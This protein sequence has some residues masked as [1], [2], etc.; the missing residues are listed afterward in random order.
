MSKV[1]A[2]RSQLRFLGGDRAGLAVGLDTQST[3]SQD[4]PSRSGDYRTCVLSLRH[5]Y[6]GCGMPRL[7]RSGD[8]ANQIPAARSLLFGHLPTGLRLRGMF[9]SGQWL[10][11]QVLG[12]PKLR[13]QQT[14]AEAAMMTTGPRAPGIGFRHGIGQQRDLGRPSSRPG[15]IRPRCGRLHAGELIAPPTGLTFCSV[16]N[17]RPGSVGGR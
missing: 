2:G 3:T 11:H 6:Q 17:T 9:H 7:W 12:S 16:P 13:R 10:R 1:S 5:V 15:S 4:T 14:R 8:R